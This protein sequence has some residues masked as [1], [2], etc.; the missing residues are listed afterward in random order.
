VKLV[1]ALVGGK[2]AQSLSDITVEAVLSF[3]RDMAAG[4]LVAIGDELYR[5]SK[6]H[7]GVMFEPLGGDDS[8]APRFGRLVAMLPQLEAAAGA[9]GRELT[10][11]F[12]SVAHEDGCVLRSFE[13]PMYTHHVKTYEQPPH[14][15]RA[16]LAL[17]RKLLTI[18]VRPAL[19]SEEVL[20][21]HIES[22]FAAR[23][24][25]RIGELTED[26]E[27]WVPPVAPPCPACTS[28]A[29]IPIVRGMPTR[30]AKEAAARGEAVIGG[31]L[32]GSDSTLWK[33]RACRHE[34]GRFG[35]FKETND[36]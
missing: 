10:W 34:F 30:G 33:C 23:L 21:R 12:V 28:S 24:V 27:T 7:E 36:G 31:C 18:I 9:S 3:D 5:A 22:G 14:L 16:D 4:D 13:W 2:P 25:R 35:D 32:V 17:C 6:H 1:R 8:R 29:V 20:V 19:R 26:P 11:P 15:E